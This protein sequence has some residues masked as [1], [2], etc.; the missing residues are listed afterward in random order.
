MT[1]YKNRILASLPDEEIERISADMEAVEVRVGDILSEAGEPVA[2]VFFPES[3]I[4]SLIALLPEGGSL[5]VAP[6]G[7][8][9]AVGIWSLT[10]DAA[11]PWRMLVQADGTVH[12]LSPADFHKHARQNP[13]FLE[14]L[15][16]FSGQ[17]L[18]LV[19]QA[20]LCNRFH[21]LSERLAFWLLCVHDRIDGDE[22]EITHEIAADMLGVHRPSATVAFSALESEGG[23]ERRSRGR[24]VVVDRAALEAAACE[25]YAAVRPLKEEA[26]RVE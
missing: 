26:V 20:A 7:R 10:R 15:I 12:R 5:E 21:P 23:I 17:V 4:V 14:A 3:G 8:E 13:R 16:G 24:V 19:S 2:G 18:E 11:S 22:M 6:I 1:E 25:C 9:G